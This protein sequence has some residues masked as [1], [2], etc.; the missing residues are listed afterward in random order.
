MT[1]HFLPDSTSTFFPNDQSLNKTP[2]GTLGKIQRTNNILEKSG[3]L[4]GKKPRNNLWDYLGEWMD[5][6][7]G[8]GGKRRPRSIDTTL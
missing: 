8:G 1:N 3:I 2:R 7:G 6:G 5:R 4:G